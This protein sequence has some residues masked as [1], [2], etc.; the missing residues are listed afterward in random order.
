MLRVCRFVTLAMAG[1]APA[2][3]QSA[4]FRPFNLDGPWTAA[5]GVVQFN[6]VH[7]F[8][9]SAGTERKVSNYPT[10][11][12]ATGLTSRAM[13]GMHYTSN[14]LLV[15]SPYTPNEVELF[16]R[17]RM[18]GVEGDGL[19]VG[20]TPAFN[21]AAQSFDGELAVAYTAGWVTLTGAARYLNKPLGTPGGDVALGAGAVVRLNDYVALA[22]DIGKLLGADTAAA[23]SAG[24]SLLI[25]GS[26]HT[27]SL[28]ASNALANTMQSASVGFREVLYGFEFTIPLHLARFAP[29]FRGRGARRATQPGDAAAVVEMRDFR[30]A[31]DTVIMTAGQ[32]VRWINADPVD[33][34]V[35]FTA[36]GAA[37]SSTLARGDAFVARFDHPGAYPYH[38]AP[39]PYM[40]GVVI[41]R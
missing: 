28:H 2:A 10:F 7:R 12:F 30:F 14:S 11:T 5:P 18:L 19:S 8:Y 39:H 33:H 23:W 24:I 22:G 25:P 21:T 32:A 9:V 4:L 15:T 29:W 35:T 40:R 38:C 36:A 6:F 3:A 41:V 34:T 37:S 13:V 20:V 17:A 1:A 31:P 16:A 27:F 26:P